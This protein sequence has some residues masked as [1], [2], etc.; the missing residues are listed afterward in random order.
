[1][2]TEL[3]CHTTASDGT[4]S[5]TALVQLAQQRN[6]GVIAITDHDTVAGHKE[7]IA[8]G[9]ALGLRVLRGIEVS[10][11]SDEGKEVHVLGYGV[12]PSDDATRSK[13]ESLR[14]VRE[15]RAKALLAKLSA[16]G[17]SISLDRV[18]AFAGDGMIGRPHVAR[19]M[20]EAGVVQ[21]LN[22]AFDEY[23]GEGKPAFVAHEGLTPQQAIALIH[24]A[25]GAA[26]LAHPMLYKGDLNTLLED[27]IVAGLDGIEAFYPMHT[28]EQTQAFVRLA[29]KQ[30]LI[31]TGGSDFHGPLGDLEISLGTIAL[32][33]DAIARLD[34]RIQQYS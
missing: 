17:I 15:A 1:L 5:P 11:L 22:Q 3:H 12:Q 21:T 23:L 9:N 20:L 19:A 31:V 30:G 8:E 28:P 10:A 29:D 4:L 33:E 7:A 13:L 27:T 6:I 25:H 26:V 18:K 14:D 34:E 24:K 2:R 16:L 32:P